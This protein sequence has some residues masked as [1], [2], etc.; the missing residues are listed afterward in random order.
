MWPQFLVFVCIGALLIAYAVT[1][2]LFYRKSRKWVCKQGQVVSTDLE[3]FPGVGRFTRY[4]IWRPRIHY[5]YE[6]DKVQKFDSKLALDKHSYE[7]VNKGAAQK[8]LEQYPKHRSV[9]VYLSANGD[10]VLLNDI[11]WPR[12][13]H[14]LAIGLAGVLI[15]T[16]GLAL[17][18]LF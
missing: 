3:E 4:S 13:S 2:A 16:L 8:F 1:A 11:D 5:S 12:K 6:T 7:F 14:Y 17:A 10:A 18:V 15:A 9:P